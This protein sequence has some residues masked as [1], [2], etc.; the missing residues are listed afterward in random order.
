MS[1]LYQKDREVARIIQADW[2]RQQHRLQMIPSE[3]YISRPVAEATASIL[4][5]KYAEGYPGQRYYEGCEY[6]DQIEELARERVLKLFSAEHANVQPHSG[7]QA[8]MGAYLGLLE[9]GDTI[10]GM[11]L[12]EGGHLTHGHPVNFSARWFRSV[13]YGVGR[14][15]ETIDYEEVRQTALKARPKIIVAGATAYPRILDFEQ[16]RRIADEV[17]ALLMVDMAHIAGLVAG[18]VHP[19][20]VPWAD[21]ITSS[22][23]KTLRGPR[24]GFILCKAKYAQRIDR[25]VFP[26]V[27]GGP[28]MHVIAAKAVAFGE[29]LRP[30]FRDY[31]RR[32]VQNAKALADELKSLGLRLVSGGTDTH[33]LLVDLSPLKITGRD[34]AKALDRA[35]I[36]VNK[37]TIPFDRRGPTVTSGIRLGTPAITTRGMGVEEMRFIARMIVRV[38]G[39]L[40]DER[41]LR[42]VR[43]EVYQLCERFPIPEVFE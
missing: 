41:V 23:H 16:F 9:P 20:P 8:N 17:G 38:L 28:L 1:L 40:D 19:S 12:S 29:A 27:Q 5:N 42:E 15:T 33:L 43:E 18:G 37:N 25:G 11:R 13:S 4:T 14:E 39:H 24:G 35:G 21:V 36:T 6:A 30:S 32:V 34:A 31:A 10:M 26:G 3:N 22:T 7:S 2:E